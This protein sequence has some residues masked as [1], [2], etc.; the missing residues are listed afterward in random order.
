MREGELGRKD[1]AKEWE[2]RRREGAK[3]VQL[4]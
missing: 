3:A 2:D 1:G 4:R